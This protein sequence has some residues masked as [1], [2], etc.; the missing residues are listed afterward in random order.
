LIT[1]RNVAVFGWIGASLIKSSSVLLVRMLAAGIRVGQIRVGQI[2]V[3][4]NLPALRLATNKNHRA[5]LTAKSLAGIPMTTVI[6]R[7]KNAAKVF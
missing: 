3:G 2:R 6:A 5:R 1:A 7:T 4:Q